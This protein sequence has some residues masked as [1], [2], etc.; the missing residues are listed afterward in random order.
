MGTL[1]EY[2]NFIKYKEEQEKRF[3]EATVVVNNIIDA[4]YKIEQV[5]VTGYIPKNSRKSEYLYG[6]L[7]NMQLTSKNM[8]SLENINLHYESYNSIESICNQYL[9]KEG[10]EDEK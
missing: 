6:M 3:R 4:S 7:E 9:K 5:T 2:N 8:N 1:E 10:N